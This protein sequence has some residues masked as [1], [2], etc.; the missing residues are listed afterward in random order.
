MNK[1][2]IIEFYGATCPF[3]IRM[4]P[5][6][7]RLE[8]EEAVV[9]DRLEVWNNAENKS[10]MEALTELYEK[11]CNGNMVVP[12]FYDAETNRLICN[13]GSYEALKKWVFDAGLF[14]YQ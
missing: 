14:R 13:P 11:E 1:K 10:K 6:V 9:V 5:H 12:S 2:H 3:C 7:D 8:T 4:A